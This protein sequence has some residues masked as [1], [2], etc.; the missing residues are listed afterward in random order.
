M[1]GQ[2]IERVHDRLVELEA[3]LAAKRWQARRAIRRVLLERLGIDDTPQPSADVTLGTAAAHLE[4][5]ALQLE[6]D[7]QA[8]TTAPWHLRRTAEALRACM[9]SPPAANDVAAA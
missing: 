4:A 8:L 5:V 7:P 2:L 6:G 3:D 9:S 1:I